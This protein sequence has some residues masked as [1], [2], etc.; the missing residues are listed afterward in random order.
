[1]DNEMTQQNAEGVLAVCSRKKNDKSPVVFYA[2]RMNFKGETILYSDVE[3]IRTY[4]SHTSYNLLFE[5]YS[6]YFQFRL[7]DGRKLKWK[8]GSWGFFGI[9]SIKRKKEYYAQFWAACVAT[10][11]KSV[12]AGIIQQI[13]MGSTVK[14]GGITISPTDISAK[15]GLK[16]ISIPFTEIKDADAYHGSI[17]IHKHDGKNAFN[18]V[19][20]AVDNAICLLYIINS[21]TGAPVS[22]SMGEEEQQ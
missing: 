4:G 10:V 20:T 9:N 1:M 18:C 12:A 8:V 19:M 16:T 22:E 14:I 13:K 17:Y 6:S 11:V 2:D 21:M 5:T 3:T 15:H 7:K